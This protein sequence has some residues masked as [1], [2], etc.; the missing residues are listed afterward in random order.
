MPDRGGASADAALMPVTVPIPAVDT[1]V[2]I[3]LALGVPIMLQSSASLFWRMDANGQVFYNYAA[4]WP[5]TVVPPGY[6]RT[7][8]A[9]AA[10]T[11]DPNNDSFEFA[12]AFD[13]VPH[14]PFTGV[15]TA[16]STDEISLFVISNSIIDVS[17]APPVSVQV[18]NTDDSTDLILNSFAMLTTGGALA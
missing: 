15:D 18:K 17:L 13:G 12:I 11:I 16:N 7:V 14:A 3:N 9:Q 8:R 4:D 2:D 6:E 5:T 1:W 10:L